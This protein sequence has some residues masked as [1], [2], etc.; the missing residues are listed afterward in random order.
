MDRSLRHMEKAEKPNKINYALPL[1]MV[2]LN[3]AGD[4]AKVNE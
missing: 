2:I 4:D 3:V 1:L